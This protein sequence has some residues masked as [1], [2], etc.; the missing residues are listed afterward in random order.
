MDDYSRRGYARLIVDLANSDR[1][2]SFQHGLAHSKGVTQELSR[3][4]QLAKEL[5]EINNVEPAAKSDQSQTGYS[6]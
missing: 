4:L 3:L 6:G 2:G 1:D 5:G